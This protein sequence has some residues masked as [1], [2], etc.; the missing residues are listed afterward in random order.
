VDT[1]DRLAFSAKRKTVQSLSAMRIPLCVRKYICGTD[2]F[3]RHRCVVTLLKAFQPKTIL[4]VGG[5][6]L[7]ARFMDSTVLSANVKN[8]EVLYDGKHLPFGKDSFDAVV[9][10]D[11]LEH[12][13][14]E[15]RSQFCT[16]LL[17]VACHVVVLCAPLGTPAHVEHEKRLLA[18]RGLSAETLCYLAEHVQQGLPTPAEVVELAWMFS[19]RTYYQGSFLGV[20]NARG[21][22]LHSWLALQTI[23]NLIEDFFWSD[24]KHLKKA[25][26]CCTN[27]F[28]LVVPKGKQF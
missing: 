9:S 19:G 5:E 13:P 17:R 21:R 1:C 26:G 10:L 7:L 18:A 24:I 6:G 2:T 14:K 8:A 20:S 22:F 16:E 4:D 27:R 28:F 25:H 23:R 12:L 11:T 3:L 15:Q